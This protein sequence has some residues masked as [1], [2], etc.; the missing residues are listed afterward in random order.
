MTSLHAARVILSPSTKCSRTRESLRIH[1][2]D[3]RFMHTPVT[4]CAL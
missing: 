2:F 4:V 1:P 3:A